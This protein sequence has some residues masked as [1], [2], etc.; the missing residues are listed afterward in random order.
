MLKRDASIKADLGV[1]S[2]ARFCAGA[3]GFFPPGRVPR[4]RSDAGKARAL[5]SDGRKC[6]MRL[7]SLV[8]CASLLLTA[9]DWANPDKTLEA[10]KD[11][12]ARSAKSGTEVRCAYL[13]TV[14]DDFIVEAYQNG[15]LIPHR[16][17]KLLLDRFGAT[18]ERIN[19]AVRAG[20]WLVFHV[21]QNPMR[22]GGSKYFGVAGCFAPNEF[23]FVSGPAS[24]EWS[25][26]DN[27]KAAARFI[28]R[29]NAGTKTRAQ[30]IAK[31]WGEGDHYLRQFAG[32]GFNG[33]ALWGGAPSTWIKFVAAQVSPAKSD[34]KKAPT[35]AERLML[36]RWPVQILSA[37]YGT[38][39]KDADVTAKVKEHV[40]KLQETFSANP[41]DLGTDPNPYWNK[42]L[43]IVYMK[44]GVRREQNR[45]ENET[46]LPESFYGPQDAAELRAWL[47]E[48]RWAGPGG[49]LQRQADG[50]FTLI[51]REG[52]SRWEATGANTLRLTWPEAVPR[53]FTFDSALAG[54]SEV[55]NGAN[56]FR[57]VLQ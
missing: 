26:C 4:P 45:N 49:E 41:H 46:I 23:G 48:T 24:P 32:E 30:T 36:K 3:G 16:K 22:W 14:A 11:S 8:F 1:S 38:G 51:G 28:H 20:D 37:V 18:G 53:D 2:E 13:I 54:F 35:V 25:V 19:V 40:E 57:P 17:R 29:R 5:G 27:P 7:S 10:W 43:R 12:A 47:I 9:F 33:K 52:A 21:V 15:K 42:N 39:G 6:F 31:P 55:K 44:D 56:V 34:E 50:T